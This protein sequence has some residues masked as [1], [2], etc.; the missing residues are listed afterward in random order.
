M[1]YRI[2]LRGRDTTDMAGMGGTCQ[3]YIGGDTWITSKR[4]EQVSLL[5]IY[6]LF[7]QFT[8]KIS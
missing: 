4:G 8:L 2:A 5:I 3:T 1:T 6:T 7:I